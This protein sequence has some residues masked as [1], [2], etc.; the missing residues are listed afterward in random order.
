MIAEIRA[1]GISF[2]SAAICL[3]YLSYSSIPGK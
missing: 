3:D 1:A 2:L